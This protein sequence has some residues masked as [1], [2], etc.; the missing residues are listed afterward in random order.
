MCECEQG[1]QERGRFDKTF[2]GDFWGALSEDKVIS[3]LRRHP[4]ASLQQAPGGK[5]CPDQGSLLHC[6]GAG[7]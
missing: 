5:G 7:V 6:R 4:A 1:L 3:G 2:P